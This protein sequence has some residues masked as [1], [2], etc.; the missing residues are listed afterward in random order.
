MIHNNIELLTLTKD[1]M[2]EIHKMTLLLSN[3]QF[4]GEGKNINE[5]ISSASSIAALH[6]KKHYNYEFIKNLVSH[7]SSQEND[8]LETLFEKGKLTHENLYGAL[9]NKLER[10]GC[11]INGLKQLEGPE[12]GALS[13]TQPI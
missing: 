8:H 4:F 12:S 13:N 3:M 11:I 5:S 9:K 7:S 2:I 10:L 6:G 1:L